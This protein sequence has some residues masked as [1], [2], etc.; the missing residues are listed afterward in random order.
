MAKKKIEPLSRNILPDC[1]KKFEHYSEEE[2]TS[3]KALVLEYLQT[4]DLQDESFW[5][6]AITK[7][8]LDELQKPSLFFKE[9]GV[10]YDTL[11][12]S[13]E[14]QEFFE[15][16]MD[17]CIN[18]RFIQGVYFPGYFYYYLNYSLIAVSDKVNTKSFS[19]TF[20]RI[21]ITD[22]QF[23]H[24]VEL[25]EMTDHNGGVLKKRRGG[26]SVKFGSMLARNFY[27][28]PGCNQMVLATDE[29]YLS[30]M[31][32]N[33]EHHLSHNDE[34]C[35][36]KSVR[37]KVNNTKKIVNSWE[38][39]TE[40]GA[41]V[42]K[43]SKSTIILLNVSDPNK[44]RGSKARLILFEEFGNFAGGLDSW[45]ISDPIVRENGLCV[46]I[47]FFIGTGGT[48]DNN[49]FE[50]INKMFLNPSAYQILSVKNIYTEGKSNQDIAYFV[51][52]YYGWDLR[53]DELGFTDVEIAKQDII[54]INEPVDKDGKLSLSQ[55]EV[56]KN[57]AERPFDPYQALGVKM[58]TAFD[59]A[60]CMDALERMEIDNF[61]LVKKGARVGRLTRNSLN[62]AEFV[63]DP[64]MKA[65]S[66][67]P[68]P[69]SFNKKGAVVIY[70]EPEYLSNG[71]IQFGRYIV[72]I[73]TYSQDIAKKGSLYAAIV[74]DRYTNEIVAEYYGRV[75]NYDVENEIS[76][77]LTMFYNAI[78]IPERNVNNTIKHFIRRGGVKYLAKQSDLT[79]R[80]GS[81][82]Y[83]ISMQIGNIKDADRE[84][85][86]YLK[87]H[88]SD[89][90][91]VTGEV[92][93]DSIQ[94]AFK[95]PSIRLLSEMT[96]YDYEMN[97]DAISAFRLIMLYVSSV[98]L[99]KHPGYFRSGKIEEKRKSFHDRLHEKMY[100]Q[101]HTIR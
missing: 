71:T 12:E 87:T 6:G 9:H 55:D 2:F 61:L 90:D 95:I 96:L 62:Q 47:K 39:T 59:A 16:E 10:Y 70:K 92:G 58:A 56:N 98:P 23:F 97:V 20:P 27:L 79:K 17:Y 42:L 48:I 99:V 5:R 69:D 15:R 41:K 26:Y 54:A 8:I 66:Q 94:G 50:A 75:N 37:T 21:W 1:L 46:G 7:E 36:W 43:G 65:I 74:F 84:I 22:L 34:H 11:W 88:Y 30:D 40:D 60:L 67:F 77:N 82:D 3:S 76:L 29:K 93:E 68:L 4:V 89:W 64:T 86:T 24:Y 33:I 78:A 32:T 63:E 35:S 101:K 51:P 25:A 85:E 38:E 14:N 44:T 13:Y 57:W 81:G 45:R 100:K 72:G 18:G 83:G 73:D 19:F 91:T 31:R 52:A 28:D 49:S 80:D 53:V